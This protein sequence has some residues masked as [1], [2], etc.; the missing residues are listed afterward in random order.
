MTIERFGAAPTGPGGRSLPFTKAVRAGDFIFVSGQVPMG[1]DG[2]I[3]DG[4]IATQTRQTI[5]NVKAILQAQGLGLEHVVKATVWLADTRDFWPFNKVYLDYFGAALPARSCVRAD[6]M[7][8]CKV[9][10][11]VVAYDPK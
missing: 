3:V 11:E 2:E 4:T 1:A 5:E 9:E 10:I 7:V 8:D 6:M